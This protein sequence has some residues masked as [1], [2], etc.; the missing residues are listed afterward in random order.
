MDKTIAAL[1]LLSLSACYDSHAGY[2]VEGVKLDIQLKT[3]EHSYWCWAA[4]TQSLLAWQGVER[5]QCEI[6]SKAF[7]R[8]CCTAES[9]CNNAFHLTQ[10]EDAGLVQQVY[11][12]QTYKDE[13]KTQL[14][15][16][17]PVV[18][19]YAHPKAAHFV[20]LTGFGPAVGL[21][22][23]EFEVQ[24]SAYLQEYVKSAATYDDIVAGNLAILSGSG[25]V[26]KQ[27]IPIVMQ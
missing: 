13:L 6:V 11:D 12:Y 21:A 5:S 20:I 1:S 17:R 4:I 25:W 23:N 2:E 24:N 3:Q 7:K 14:S 22:E 8:D 27:T 16:N 15:W 10:L 26:W 19:Y 9:K 18:L